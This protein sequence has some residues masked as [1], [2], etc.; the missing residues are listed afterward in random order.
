MSLT[1]QM[2]IDQIIVIENGTVMYR[3]ATKIIEDG[4]ELSK[5]YH[6]TSLIPA[7]N[8]TGVPANVVAICNT[9]WTA[10]VVAAYQ[11]AQAAAEAAR[12]T[13]A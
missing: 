4:N 12:N 5:T 3:E 13:V 9:V 7:Q 10:E 11:A 8:L 6:R 1:K 2:V